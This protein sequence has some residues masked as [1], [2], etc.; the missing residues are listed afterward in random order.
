MT[1][2]APSDPADPAA[3]VRAAA[4]RPSPTKR[5]ALELFR[6]LPHRYDRL[7]AA[8]SFHQDPRWRRALVDAIAPAGGERILDVATGTGMVAAELLARDG[9]CTVVGLD[10]SVEMLAGAR[11]RFDAGADGARVELVEGEAERLPFADAA[12][13]AL[14]FTYLLRYVDDPRA[15]MRELAR[16]LRPGGRIASLEFGVPPRPVPRLAWRLYTAVGLPVLGRLFSRDW[17][18]VGRFLGPS[19]AGFYARH[20]LDALVGYWREAGLQDVRVRRM[21]LGGGVV[22]SARRSSS[23]P[24][25]PS[26]PAASLTAF[27]SGSGAGSP[28]S[29]AQADARER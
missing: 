21:S 19:I 13:D 27:V 2:N 5:Q 22:M 14:T 1:A 12:F 24:P 16:V 4:D 11:A 3:S 17:A 25:E 23:S 10:Q 20:P 7:S 6:G 29:G 18:A 8:L 15:T 28:S 9:D 26:A